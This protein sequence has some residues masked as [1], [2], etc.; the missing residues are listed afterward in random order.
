MVIMSKN[1]SCLLS[2]VTTLSTHNRRPVSGPIQRCQYRLCT[3]IIKEGDAIRTYIIYT[4]P[5]YTTLFSNALICKWFHVF[6]FLVFQ[7][8]CLFFCADFSE[9]SAENDRY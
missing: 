2:S 4:L 3:I 8:M 5:A 1:V 9:I 6:G 7:K